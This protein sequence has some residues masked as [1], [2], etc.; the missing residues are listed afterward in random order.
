MRTLD[1]D[2]TIAYGQEWA[3]QFRRDAFAGYP[4]GSREAYAC[5]KI[6][7]AFEEFLK[8]LDQQAIEV[9]VA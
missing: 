9:K 4:A 3:R 2:L 8:Q 5:L 1:A 6:A 7:N